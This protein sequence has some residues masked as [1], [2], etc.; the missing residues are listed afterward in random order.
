MHKRQADEGKRPV[1]SMDYFFMRHDDKKPMITMLAV[2]ESRYK[3]IMATIAQKK[4]ASEPG[5][6][7]RVAQFIN[8]LGYKEITLKSDGE[9]AIVALRSEIK[10]TCSAE[11]TTGDSVPGDKLTNGSA[12][13][14]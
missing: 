10:Q 1:I 4:G 3:N 12:E 9:P 13:M 2:K 11:V 14:R 6:A 8:A 5:V 7:D